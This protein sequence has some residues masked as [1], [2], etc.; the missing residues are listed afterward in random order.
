MH[1]SILGAMAGSVGAME[2]VA[3]VLATLSL[4]ATPGPTNTLLATSGASIGIRRS[5]PLLAAELAGYF[6]AIL[7]LRTVVGPF[8]AAVPAFGTALRVI[9]TVYL[10]YLAAVLWHHGATEQP[11]GPV[12][13]PRVFITTLLN[14]KA[15]IFAFV[16]LPSGRDIA[17]LLPWLLCLALQI[18]I[19]GGAWIAAGASLRRGFQAGDSSRTVYRV[20]AVALMVIAGAIGAQAVG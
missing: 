15:I 18:F 12:T 7:F 17:G 13:F 10:L 3:F 9:V 11:A 5:L 16:I 19:V 20:S 4:L 2:P 1:C 14:P 6:L 8:V